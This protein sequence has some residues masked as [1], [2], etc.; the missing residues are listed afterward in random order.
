MGEQS[1]RLTNLV[2]AEPDEALF[3]VPSDFRVL[4]GPKQIMYRSNR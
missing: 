4:D 1:F 2:R 3:S